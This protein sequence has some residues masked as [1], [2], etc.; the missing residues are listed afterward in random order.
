[1]SRQPVS[2]PVETGIKAPASFS[3]TLAKEEPKP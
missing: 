1:M 2:E 3:S